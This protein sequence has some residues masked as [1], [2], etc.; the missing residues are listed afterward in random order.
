MREPDSSLY[1]YLFHHIYHSII[2]L[3]TH[4]GFIRGLT[5]LLFVSI[6]L[7]SAFFPI[8]LIYWMYFQS[9]TLL[10]YSMNEASVNIK[11]PDLI[12]FASKLSQ[13]VLDLI[14]FTANAIV[15]L[16]STFTSRP[17]MMECISYHSRLVIERV[18][19]VLLCM[20]WKSH[21]SVFYLTSILII[22]IRDLFKGPISL[23]RFAKTA[24]NENF[25]R[26]ERWRLALMTSVLDWFLPG[27]NTTCNNR[28]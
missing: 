26:L 15:S 20:D 11:V 4:Y 18:S 25:S 28:Y 3:L 8:Y 22:N 9:R 1:L 27:R 13:A 16:P 6:W 21:I 24:H 7:V 19:E 10:R 17:P 23:P 12:E 5:L 2:I 14:I